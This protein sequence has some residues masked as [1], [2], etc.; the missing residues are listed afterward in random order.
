MS[1]PLHPLRRARLTV[2]GW[3]AVVLGVMG[4]LVLLSAVVGTALLNRTDVVSRLLSQEIQPAGWP[5]LSCRR[6]CATRKPVS[7]AT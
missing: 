6:R 5:P 3:L 1:A 4:V 2:R 7:A